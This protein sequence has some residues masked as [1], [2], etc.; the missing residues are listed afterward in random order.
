M[1]GPVSS[2]NLNNALS[3]VCNVRVKCFSYLDIRRLHSLHS[4]ISFS[5]AVF[6]EKRSIDTSLYGI[7]YSILL[8]N[9]SSRHDRY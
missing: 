1:E 5:I 7:D 8:K 3:D 4:K 6:R 2:H 9:R